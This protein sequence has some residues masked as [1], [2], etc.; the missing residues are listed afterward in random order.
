MPSVRS[1]PS[2]KRLDVGAKFTYQDITYKKVDS[3][4][5]FKMLPNGSSQTQKIVFAK[6]THVKLLAAK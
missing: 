5:A 3:K 6:S 1:L 2:F 4:H